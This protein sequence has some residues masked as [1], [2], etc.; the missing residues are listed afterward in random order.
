MPAIWVAKSFKK[1]HSKVISTQQINAKSSATANKTDHWIRTIKRIDFLLCA[2]WKQLSIQSTFSGTL[3]YKYCVQFS[4][5]NDTSPV[6]WRSLQ[7]S[8][9]KTFGCVSRTDLRDLDR[10]IRAPLRC[11]CRK[12]RSSR[13]VECPLKPRDTRSQS[14]NQF[15]NTTTYTIRGNVHQC[16]IHGIAQIV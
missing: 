9:E 15:I 1:H 7:S 6:E 2:T 14:R 12:D 5:W 11:V 13:P 3:G 4:K 16:H 10:A 8:L